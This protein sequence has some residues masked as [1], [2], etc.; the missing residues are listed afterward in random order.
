[1]RVAKTNV[2][3]YGSLSR[4]LAATIIGYFIILYFYINK[5]MRLERL[6]RIVLVLVRIQ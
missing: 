5:N 4:H 2:Q 3:R 6:K 1:M